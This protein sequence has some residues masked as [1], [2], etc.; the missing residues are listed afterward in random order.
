MAFVVIALALVALVTIPLLVLG[1]VAIVGVF[2]PEVRR[3]A[4]EQLSRPFT[5]RFG[6][7]SEFALHRQRRALEDDAIRRY[8]Q[9]GA[10]EES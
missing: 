3:K 2:A 7:K 6:T 9:R 4:F 10:Q 8:G 5:M 1:V